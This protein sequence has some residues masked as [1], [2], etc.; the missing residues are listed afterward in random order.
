[1]IS[2]RYLL[3][4]VKYYVIKCLEGRVTP[5]RG[6]IVQCRASMGFS[7]VCIAGLLKEV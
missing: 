4:L 3:L 7:G 6:E 5:W 1:M 2:L